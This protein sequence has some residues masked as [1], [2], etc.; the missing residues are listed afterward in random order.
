MAERIKSTVFEALHRIVLGHW[1]R[2]GNR[3]W[4]LNFLFWLWFFLLWFLLLRLFLLRFLFLG[5]LLLG[6]FLLGLFLL[7]LRLFRGELDFRVKDN[8]ACADLFVLVCIEQ[9]NFNV[10]KLSLL[11]YQIRDWN[12]LFADEFVLSFVLVVDFELDF[13]FINDIQFENFVPDGYLPALL[14]NF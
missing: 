4:L 12:C 1:L 9:L 3:L 6:L 5:L 11:L 13:L 2:L 7:G 14:H 10:L 8:H